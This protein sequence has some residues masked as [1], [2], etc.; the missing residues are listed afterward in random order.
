MRKESDCDYDKPT[1]SVVIC[2]RYSVMV[3]KIMVYIILC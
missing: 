2:N 1:I 3:N